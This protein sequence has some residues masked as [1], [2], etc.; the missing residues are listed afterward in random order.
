[1][2]CRELSQ[3]KNILLNVSKNCNLFFYDYSNFLGFSLI[4]LHIGYLGAKLYTIVKFSSC[5]LF[6]VHKK[7]LEIYISG[8][9]YLRE[10]LSLYI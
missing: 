2:S 5:P 10:V 9:R 6:P 8:M 3:E 7:W 4:S 1:M